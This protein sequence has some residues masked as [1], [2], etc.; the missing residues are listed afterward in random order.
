MNQVV[1]AISRL[2]PGALASLLLIFAGLIL[3]GANSAAGAAL[4]SMVLLALLVLACANRSSQALSAFA[5]A[6]WLS[7]L[8]FGVFLAVAFGASLVHWRPQVGDLPASTRWGGPTMALSPYR[9]IEGIAALFGPAAA[10]MLGSLFSAEREQRDWIGRWVA[11]LTLLYC[12]YALWLFFAAQSAGRLDAGISSANGAADV[13]IILALTAAAIVVRGA[14]GHLS[15]AARRT[16]DGPRTPALLRT[17]FALG[18]LI[19]SFTCL[20]LTASRAG[21]VAGAIGVLVFA[22]AIGAQMMKGQGGRR[23]MLAIPVL[24]MAAA[25]AVLFWRGGDDVLERFALADQDLAI[26]RQIALA[27][28]PFFS[29]SPVFGQGLGAYYELNTLA[30][31]PENWTA[32]RPAGSVHNIYIQAL[33]ET[34]LVGLGLLGLMLATPL[35]RAMRRGFGPHSGAEYAAAAFAGAIVLF[36]HGFTD[37]GLQT[38]AIAALFAF[39][40]GAF[41]PPYRKRA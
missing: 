7:I 18:A 26:R 12:A 6:N 3:Y 32:L 16:T 22:S 35:E 29:E 15:G 30:A 36:A 39:V 10:F 21:L 41:A 40:L 38:P 1:H 34:G 28:W 8:A 17:P 13:F 4:L 9:S 20:L 33:E 19:L 27:H 14:R 25:L 24:V 2:N 31:H 23:G 5:R 11:L 37:F